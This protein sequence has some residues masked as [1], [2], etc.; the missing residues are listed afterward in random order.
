M[1]FLP[2]LVALVSVWW[3]H[4]G[5]DI[6]LRVYFAVIAAALSLAFIAD[7][8]LYPFWGFKLNAS[9]LQYLT[10]PTEAMASVSTGYL[11]L[12]LV[13]LILLGYLVYLGYTCPRWHLAP[14]SHRLMEAVA[15]LLLWNRVP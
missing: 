6:L 14:S 4:R 8:S 5:L 3:Y 12:R 2:L 9:C 7:A 10:T 13:V 11:L 15:G 1:L